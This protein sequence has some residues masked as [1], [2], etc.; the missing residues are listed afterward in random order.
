MDRVRTHTRMDGWTAAKSLCHST[1]SSIMKGCAGEGASSASPDSPVCSPSEGLQEWL[2]QV[3][4][5]QEQA[6]FLWH[7]ALMGEWTPGVPVEEGSA[8]VAGWERDWWNALRSW[9]IHQRDLDL[10][11][12]RDRRIEGREKKAEQRRIW[13]EDRD[14]KVAADA[15]LQRWRR[16][17]EAMRK[18]DMLA[19]RVEQE[20][21][22]S[23]KRKEEEESGVVEERMRQQEEARRQQYKANNVY[24]AAWAQVM[25]D[26]IRW[27][28]GWDRAGVE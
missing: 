7:R 18:E 13:A 24:A 16:E 4:E 17:M 26:G 14:R 22:L 11:V 19:N 28:E 23:L 9:E 15:E 12:E 10:I 21:K 1:A 2:S 3:Q 27:R 6:A 20:D 5:R 25:A 8:P